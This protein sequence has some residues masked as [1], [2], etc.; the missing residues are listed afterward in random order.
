MLPCVAYILE[1]LQR[2]FSSENGNTATAVIKA[3]QKCTSEALYSPYLA[4]VCYFYMHLVFI[5]FLL[6]VCVDELLEPGLECH[7]LNKYYFV[8]IF[9]FSPEIHSYFKVLKGRIL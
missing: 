8:L 2:F 1:R 6:S 9:F 3:V 4:D 7:H 5:L